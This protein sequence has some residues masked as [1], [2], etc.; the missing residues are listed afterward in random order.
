LSDDWIS[1][2]ELAKSITAMSRAALRDLV[3]DLIARTLLVRSD[4]AED[5]RE[6]AL[7]S[8]SSWN[9]AAG[10]FHFTTKNVAPPRNLEHAERELR[11]RHAVGGSPDR[12][13]RYARATTLSLP[14]PRRDGQ[15]A[16]VLLA[17]RTWRRFGAGPISLGDVATM[18]WLTCG[19]QRTAEAV[20]LGSVSLTTSPSGGARHP[21]EAYLLAARVDDLA[22]GLYH[23][24][25][26]D[27]LLERLK[28]GASAATIRR[29]IPGQWWYER[30]AALLI[31]TA[32][33]PRTQWRY[34]FPRAYRNVLLEAG[35]VCQTFCLAAT[36]L[37]H[38]PFCTARFSDSVV[39]SAIGADGVTE[40][41]V[42]GAG[43]GL[44]PAG[45]EWAPWPTDHEEGRPLKRRKPRSPTS[46][47]DT[48]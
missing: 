40:S 5:P 33:F 11:D 6:T 4:Q 36:W 31:L 21:L 27:H 37:G 32:V 9:P 25:P 41:F 47:G 13:K 16:E 8:W 38:A 34:Q 46:V 12:F 44:R 18:L 15:F 23:Y 43:V 22:P 45:V 10:F 3:R 2:T 24:A 29:Y 48:E 39:E 30:A 17:R 42:Y 26:G 35:H 7:A 1:V 14:E 28:T 20:G 19:V